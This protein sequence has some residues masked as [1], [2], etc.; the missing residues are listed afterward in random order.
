MK[1][2]TDQYLPADQ[3]NVKS[4]FNASTNSEDS[5]CSLHE[6]SRKRDHYLST[7]GSSMHTLILASLQRSLL[8]A[9]K[10]ACSQHF[11]SKSTSL[12]VTFIN[13]LILAVAFALQTFNI[14]VLCISESCLVH[15][16]GPLLLLL[17]QLAPKVPAEQASIKT[18]PP[19]H[20]RTKTR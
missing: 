4:L 10:P 13:P 9:A 8:E 19:Q 6:K 20:Y 11:A 5:I 18:P 7:S 17:I 16:N 12:F 15:S 3:C 2:I 1:I 14:N